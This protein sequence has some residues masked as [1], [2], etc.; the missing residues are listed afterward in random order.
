MPFYL[1]DRQHMIFKTRSYTKYFISLAFSIVF[2]TTIVADKRITT[3]PLPQ[4][5]LTLPSTESRA[6][7]SRLRKT[8]K[9]KTKKKTIRS[10][11]YEELAAA[12]D[13]QL[14]NS[15]KESA[16]KYLEQMMK[17]CNDVQKLGAHLL[18]LSDLLFDLGKFSQAALAYTEFSNLY[19]GSNDIEYALYRAIL[20]TFYCT[21][22]TERDQTKTEE[23]VAL[24]DTFLGHDPEFNTYKKE[25]ITIREQCYIKLVEN[26]FDICNFYLNKKSY[27]AVNR[28]LDSLRNE[29]LEKLPDIEPRII[30]FEADL[31]QKQ[32]DQQLAMKKQ[33]ELA[34]KFPT[35]STQ[36]AQ[37]KTKKSMADRF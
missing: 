7:K 1:Q 29:W 36:V 14:D 34:E 21:L 4:F 8:Y 22:D 30:A 33:Q 23:T 27:K 24:A 35:Y 16:I 37:K 28:R 11:S 10:M 13:R 26:E 32:G 18:E 3:A 15:N 31:T 20:C 19:P 5:T 25:V 12:K 2:F 6:K 9:K 17:L